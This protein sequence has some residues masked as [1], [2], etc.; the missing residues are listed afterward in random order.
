MSQALAHVRAHHAACTR[1]TTTVARAQPHPARGS[2]TLC[3][4]HTPRLESSA[5]PK[6]PTKPSAPCRPRP[7][8]GSPPAAALLVGRRGAQDPPGRLLHLG[9]LRAVRA[10]APRRRRGPGANGAAEARRGVA[11]GV[12]R[13]L[14]RHD[15]SPAPRRPPRPGPTLPRGGRRRPRHFR[16]RAFVPAPRRRVRD[17]RRRL[18]VTRAFCCGAR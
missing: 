6:P 18:L 16:A 2:P 3:A 14:P 5:A 4:S 13:P 1:S 9:R 12:R 10:P 17:R 8:H 7:G 11:A 15:P